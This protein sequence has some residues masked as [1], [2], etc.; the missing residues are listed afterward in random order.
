LRVK[1][2]FAG[3]TGQCPSCGE[4]MEIPNQDTET[5]PQKPVYDVLPEVET[6]P[7][8]ER[9]PE[10]ELVRPTPRRSRKQ[11]HG[12]DGWEPAGDVNNHA[13]GPISGKDDFFVPPP[14]EIGEVVS[15][16]TSLRKG[17]EPMS[18]GARLTVAI[19]AGAA[20]L[21][22]GVLIAV[23]LRAP[24]WQLFW[25]VVLGG[26]GLG[27][28]LLSTGF[29]HTCTYVG[30]EGVARFRCS[31]S[32]EQV[33][34]EVF[35]FADATE[36]RTS[37]TRHY[38]NGV[39]QNTAYNFTWTDAAGRARFVIGASHKS[40]QGNPP[41]KDLF[42]F[43]T[44]SEQAWTLY[45]LTEI[46]AQLRTD[47]MIYFGLGGRN[48]VKLGQERI[49]L[50]FNGEEIDCHADEISQVRIEQGW[51]QVR[52]KDAKEGWFSSRG[53]FKFPYGSLANAQLFLILMDKLVGVRING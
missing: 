1:D 7:N 2:E 46:Q 50:F 10:A 45:K 15:A 43:A 8:E 9:A 35:R 19:I 25:P 38:T 32:R 12:E 4:Q 39:Y 17:T 30:R 11:D 13:G 22:I 40:E 24:F 51:V 41:L 44:A 48:W 52:R 20:G 42:H 37:Q 26:L 47:G 33:K 23:N 36:L 34:E 14:T 16:T 31:G 3:Q 49:T 28:A 53:V 21:F 29:A 27:I 5:A 18:P 6:E